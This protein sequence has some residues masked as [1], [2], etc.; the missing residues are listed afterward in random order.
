MAE[1][2]WKDALWRLAATGA[3]RRL[4][5]RVALSA[6]LLGLATRGAAESEAGPRVPVSPALEPAATVRRFKGRYVLRRSEGSIHVHLAG[7]SSHS[8]HASHSSHSSGSHY[9][10]SHFSSS[11]FSSSPTPAPA[12]VPAPAP[13]P[14]PLILPQPEPQ[15]SSEPVPSTEPSTTP[16]STP[17]PSRSR[18]S[19]RVV[20]APPAKPA[21]LFEETFD[22]LTRDESRWRAGVLATPPQTMDFAAIVQQYRGQLR[23]TPA[24]GKSGAH[25]SGYVSLDTFNLETATLTV[26]LREAG[27]GGVTTIFAAAVDAQNWAGFRV[28]DGQ[29]AFESH[30]AG[31]VVARKVPYVAAQHRFLR[32][33]LSRVARVVVWETSSDRANWTPAYVET[34]ALNLAAL[35]LVLSAGTE[36]SIDTSTTATF[37]AV[38]VERRQ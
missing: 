8:S 1:S 32:L 15:P 18:R 17:A 21:P 30:T 35:H 10:G 29:L 11:H 31:R 13:A 16:D 34:S 14:E 38:L 4:T 33:R 5:A 3:L 27:R 26:K 25:F 23:I 2:R 6:G 12:P 36:H 20:E 19:R 37:G 28:E 22:A 9:S 7:H 24:T